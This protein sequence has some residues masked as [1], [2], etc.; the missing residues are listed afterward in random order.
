[1]IIEE[2]G[3]FE[4]DIYENIMWSENK[5]L[6]NNLIE[7]TFNLINKELTDGISQTYF[8]KYNKFIDRFKGVRS[9]ELVDL[10]GFFN[11]NI[12][13]PYRIEYK[14]KSK[15]TTVSN[16][17]ISKSVKDYRFIFYY[18]KNH[19]DYKKFLKEIIESKLNN[20]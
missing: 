15:R 4:K 13:F 11:E 8:P 17:D 10:K 5:L 19:E 16:I 3:S 12:D 18:D 1:M 6:H 7:V 14:A 9:I 20:I 2:Y